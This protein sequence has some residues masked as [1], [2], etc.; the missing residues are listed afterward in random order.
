MLGRNYRLNG[1]RYACQDL[2]NQ[3]IRKTASRPEGQ[4]CILDVGVG[5]GFADHAYWR[6]NSRLILIVN[7]MPGKKGPY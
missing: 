2:G 1:N 4:V 5:G 6:L 7:L 3:R